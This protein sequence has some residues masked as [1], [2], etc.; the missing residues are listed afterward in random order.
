MQFRSWRVFLHRFI[1]V[2]T[3]ATLLAGCVPLLADHQSARVLPRGEMEFTPSF[4]YVSFSDADGSV[5]VQD[6][7]GARL[8]YGLSKRFDIRAMF[9]HI[10]MDQDGGGSSYNVVGVGAKFGLVPDRVAFYL[11][12]GFATG[13]AVGDVSDTWTVAPTLLATWRASPQFELTPSIKAFY[14]FV[15]EDPEWFVGVHFGAGI[16]TDL[17][18][19]AFR[20]DVGLVKNLDADGTT[21]G[22]TIGVSIRP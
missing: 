15:M 5:H 12:I 7:Y 11:P 18:R 16:S 21:W 9:E 17:E 20:P 8:G 10:S 4:S 14:P 1:G 19:W 2:S 22:F 3:P 6:Q 13:E